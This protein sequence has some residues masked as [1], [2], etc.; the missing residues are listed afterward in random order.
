MGSFELGQNF[1]SG[2]LD[3]LSYLSWLNY[4]INV[5]MA[6]LTISVVLSV[7]FNAA[8]V[9]FIIKIIKN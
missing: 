9:R 6:L 1:V 4:I 7:K 5:P 8:I 3:V 2:F